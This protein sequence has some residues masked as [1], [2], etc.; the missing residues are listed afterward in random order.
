LGDI[1]STSPEPKVGILIL[2]AFLSMIASIRPQISIKE[3]V[4]LIILLM[5]FITIAFSFTRMNFL[6]QAVNILITAALIVTLI[7]LISAF[8][9]Y[10]PIPAIEVDLLNKF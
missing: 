3:T 8:I 4:Q 5:V 1:I 2:A 10:S 7:G 9:G 6:K